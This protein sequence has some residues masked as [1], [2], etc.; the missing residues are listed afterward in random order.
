MY[1]DDRRSRVNITE[2]DE[3]GSCLSQLLW[4]FGT[5]VAVVIVVVGLH[6]LLLAIGW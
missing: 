3:D 6:Y 2:G 1:D 4:F 5:L